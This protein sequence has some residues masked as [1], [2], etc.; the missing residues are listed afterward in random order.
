[1]NHEKSVLVYAPLGQDASL[2]AQVLENASMQAEVIRTPQQ[3]HTRMGA[4]SGALII[5]EEAL[6]AETLGLLKDRLA[7]QPP[8]SDLPVILLTSAKGRG[9][10]TQQILDQFAIGG[11]ISLLERPF[12]TMTLVSVIRVALRS[13]TRQYQ[14]R[15]LIESQQKALQ[16][17]DDFLSIASHELKTPITSLKLHVQMRQHLL[18]RGD[19]SV[20]QPPKVDSMIK[21]TGHLVERLSRLV[22]DMLDVSRIENGKLSLD[23]EECDLQEIARDVLKTFQSQFE[24]VQSPVRLEVEKPAVGKWDRYRL[25]QVAANLFTNAIKYG[26]GRPVEILVSADPDIARLSVKDQGIG[27]AREDQHRVFERF[28]RAV[29]NGQISGL[30]LGL[31]ISRQIIEMHGGQVFVESEPGQ[32]SKFTVE[33]PRA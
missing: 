19:R 7:N 8:W 31:F 22:D 33:L 14:V 9:F 29:P 30:G 5:A 24:A 28:E 32:G 18:N 23:R 10:D 12:R 17:R 2:A 4:N 16:Q 15:A 27:I 6:T 1:M 20:Y 11:N 3:L 26:A 21:Q 25:E 13:R